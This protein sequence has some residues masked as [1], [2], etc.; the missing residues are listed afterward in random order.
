MRAPP[1]TKFNKLVG[2]QHPQR[3]GTHNTDHKEEVW[4][5]N[6][7]YSS[8]LLCFVALHPSSLLSFCHDPSSP[9]LWKLLVRENPPN[10]KP[11][12]F[13]LPLRCDILIDR[14]DLV[15]VVIAPPTAGNNYAC[16]FH[17]QYDSSF[18][19]F[20]LVLLY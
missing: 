6:V 13:P 12:F 20:A 8:S 5:E 9:A 14:Y 10:P 18:D 19:F 16:A 15:K 11:F 1:Q 3:L 17:Y 4:S 2:F 7:T